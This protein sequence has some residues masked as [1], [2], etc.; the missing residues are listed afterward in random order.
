MK[1]LNLIR[2][3]AIIMLA[4]IPICTIAQNNSTAQNVHSKNTVAGHRICVF[5]GTEQNARSKAQAAMSSINRNF[6][7]IH[8]EV[9]YNTPIWKVHVGQC[10]NRTEATILLQRIRKIFPNAYIVSEKINIMEFT[11]DPSFTIPNRD[12]NAADTTAMANVDL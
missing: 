12:P 6:E 5:S 1:L 9:I 7:D 11:L 4:A 3:T 10:I 8:A 2:I